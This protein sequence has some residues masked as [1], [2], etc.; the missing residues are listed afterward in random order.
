MIVTLRV[1]SSAL[2]AFKAK[3]KRRV[4][5]SSLKRLG[6]EAQR[7]CFFE[8][9]SD[10][11]QLFSGRCRMLNSIASIASIAI[12]RRV[13]K[14]CSE[15]WAAAG[16]G[17]D[18]S[19][20]PEWQ[21]E[22]R[23]EGNWIETAWNRKLFKILPKTSGASLSAAEKNRSEEAR[24]HETVSFN[25][26]AVCFAGFGA[27]AASGKSCLGGGAGAKCRVQARKLRDRSGKAPERQPATVVFIQIFGIWGANS[28]SERDWGSS[29]RSSKPEG[30]AA[31]A[32][33][34]G[35]GAVA[36]FSASYEEM[37]L[38]RKEALSRDAQWQQMFRPAFHASCPELYWGY[39]Q[40]SDKHSLEMPG[41]IYWM[42]HLDHVF[43]FFPH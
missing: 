31:A 37:E 5:N 42:N 34:V 40:T 27:P 15:A 33:W 14:T 3:V 21:P 16:R 2:V 12:A 36:A 29:E 10:T 19:S 1:S 20:R 32:P 35:G 13:R 6:P 4:G 43:I 9:R 30:H 7:M 28:S 17:G 41:E 25:A 8:R 39:I 11:A 22:I 24:T 26:F 18:G 38:L 23:C